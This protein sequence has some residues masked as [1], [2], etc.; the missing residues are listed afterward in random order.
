METLRE[1]RR[2]DPESKVSPSQ[3]KTRE[4]YSATHQGVIHDRHRLAIGAD[5]RCLGAS[6][7]VNHQKKQREVRYLLSQ[8]ND[9]GFN[10]FFKYLILLDILF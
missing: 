1:C 9:P 7:I 5:L 6:R 10:S 8:A 3:G 4:K 2:Y